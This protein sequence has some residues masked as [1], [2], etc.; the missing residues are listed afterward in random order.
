MS[1]ESPQTIQQVLEE[2]RRIMRAAVPGGTLWEL[3]S[4][5]TSGPWFGDDG[6]DASCLKLLTGIRNAVSALAQAPAALQSSEV[7]VVMSKLLQRLREQ[8]SLGMTLSSITRAISRFQDEGRTDGHQRT[9]LSRGQCCSSALLSLLARAAGYES[10]AS[11]NQLHMYTEALLIT[12]TYGGDNDKLLQV[13]VSLSVETA[14]EGAAPPQMRTFKMTHESQDLH[15]SLRGTDS[16]LVEETLRAI[17]RRAHIEATKLAV[18]PATAFP[19]LAVAS[20]SDATMDA[21]VGGGVDGTPAAGV[22]DHERPRLHVAEDLAFARVSAMPLDGLQDITRGVHGI[23]LQFASLPCS[24]PGVGLRSSFELDDEKIHVD[25]HFINPKSAAGGV[26]SSVN[27]GDQSACD[28]L[29]GDNSSGVGTAD[30][31]MSTATTATKASAASD[32]QQILIE[33]DVAQPASADKSV[34]AGLFRARLCPGIGVQKLLAQSMAQLSDGQALSSDVLGGVAGSTAADTATTASAVTSAAPDENGGNN[35]V[36]NDDLGLMYLHAWCA[37]IPVPSLPTD[38]VAVKP[39]HT[40]VP[41]NV[42]SGA[43]K[44]SAGVERQ[45]AVAAVGI[46]GSS[47]QTSSNSSSALSSATTVPPPTAS[48]P[49]QAAAAIATV[50]SIDG[51]RMPVLEALA[52]INLDD[53]LSKQLY[54]LSVSNVDDQ[55]VREG[56]S[57]TTLGKKHGQKHRQPPLLSEIC[58]SVAVLSSV[59]M[60]VPHVESEH[61]ASTLRLLRAHFILGSLLHSCF[62]HT[63]AH[64]GNAVES[65][66]LETGLFYVEVKLQGPCGFVCQIRGVPD[67]PD[68]NAQV[69]LHISVDVTTNKVAGR[70]SVVEGNT[71]EPGVLPR[72][73]YCD[74]ATVSSLLQE[75]LCVP[76]LVHRVLTTALDSGTSDDNGDRNNDSDSVGAS[77]PRASSDADV[78]APPSKRPRES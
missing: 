34:G 74:D 26:T 75:D 51:K 7:S 62:S 45:S 66:K 22:D 70:L 54:C 76:V 69:N 11:D 12:V 15:A 71:A 55:L 53:V 59:S 68:A 3:A 20:G 18:L 8:S 65:D 60:A 13:D 10:S 48:I 33:Y 52:T 1:E 6:R 28:Q 46:S 32:G 21:I 25:P 42:A 67:S 50:S 44:I 57:T 5:Q 16:A 47:A 37:H 61:F 56:T 36:R 64:Y 73:T 17:K 58:E 9:A 39:L 40:V 4:L 19:P 77:V 78:G 23:K 29:A 41:Y 2:L 30:S 31:R 38:S 43:A 14:G 27:I 35:E 63:R 49:P 72:S 24:Q